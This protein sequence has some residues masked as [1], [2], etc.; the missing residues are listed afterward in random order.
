MTE[1][2]I[3][4]WKEDLERLDLNPDIVLTHNSEGEYGHKHHKNV[5][6][7][8]NEIFS[9]IWEFICPGCVNVAPQPFKQ[10]QQVIPLSP[11]TL[12]RK[13]EIFN[14]SYTSELAIWKVMPE[15]MQFEF[16][17]GPEIFTSD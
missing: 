2:E 1:A 5:N 6:K 7:I 3:E 4:D 10:I 8:V 11:D 13:T 16:R 14:R 12:N 15:P 9:N 17:T